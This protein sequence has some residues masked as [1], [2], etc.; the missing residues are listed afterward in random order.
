MKI[1]N[2]KMIFDEVICWDCKGTK[3][4][5][6]YTLCPHNTKAV[7]QFPGRKCP[8]CGSKNR[9]SHQSIGDYMTDCKICNTTGKIMENLYSHISK[10]QWAILQS[11]FK[12]TVER[13]NRGPTFNEEYLG[14]GYLYGCTDYGRTTALTDEQILAKVPFDGVPCQ[15]IA[16]VKSDGTVPSELIIKVN[17]SGYMVYPKWA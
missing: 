11:S 13:V 12:W 2:G 10:E 15:L 1:E 5:K 7:T 14:L 16:W 4:V 9:Y 3:Q 6:R 17:R 8:Q